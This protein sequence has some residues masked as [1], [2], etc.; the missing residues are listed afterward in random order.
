[1]ALKNCESAKMVD[2]EKIESPLLVEKGHIYIP[3]AG[4][5]FE[6]LRLHPG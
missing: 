1:M 5:P 3:E 4:K 2:V 6:F